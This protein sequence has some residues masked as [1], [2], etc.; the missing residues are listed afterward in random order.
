VCGVNGLD[1]VEERIIDLQV[2]IEAGDLKAL[3]AA[4]QTLAGL[5]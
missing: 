4:G 1:L 5:I 3:R 2:V